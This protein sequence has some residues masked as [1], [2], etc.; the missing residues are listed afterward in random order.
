DHS[1]PR[2][3]AGSDELLEPRGASA[4]PHGL[5]TAPESPPEMTGPN[6]AAEPTAAPQAIGPTPA[7][8]QESRSRSRRREGSTDSP[9]VAATHA[10]EP[11]LELLL[12]NLEATDGSHAWSE[13]ER[14]FINS[15]LPLQRALQQGQAPA[16]TESVLTTW[17]TDFA[18][19]Y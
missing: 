1:A 3:P 12:E 7:N 13:I 5:K 8:T 16:R 17:A 4:P 19:S 14:L 6:P 15:Y 10:S 9:Q 18:E 11:P 2:L